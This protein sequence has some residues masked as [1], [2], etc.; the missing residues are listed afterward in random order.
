M[1]GEQMA[2]NRLKCWPEVFQ[3]MLDGRKTAEYRLNDRDF[4]VGEWLLIREWC[5]EDEQYTHREMTV[6][7]THIL[8]GGFGMPKGYVMLS[9]KPP[10]M[11]TLQATVERQAAEIARYRE[12]ATAMR[13]DYQTSEQHHPDHILVMRKDFD[14]LCQ[15]LGD[16]NG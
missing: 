12:A 14:A 5:P 8:D 10:M 13:D 6:Q 4:K 11:A 1:T 16:H 9:F 2:R 3:A 15:A 7:I